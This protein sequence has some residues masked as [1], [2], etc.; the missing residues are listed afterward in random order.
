[1]SSEKDPFED[2][3]KLTD[4]TTSPIEV[5]RTLNRIGGVNVHRGV[6]EG[7]PVN[8]GA[9]FMVIGVGGFYGAGKDVY[10]DAVVDN[11]GFE[12]SFM[13][14]FLQKCIRI[15][16]PWIRIDKHVSHPLLRVVHWSPGDMVKY[17]D[18]ESW[19]NYEGA[20]EQKEVREWLQLMGTEVGRKILGED[21]WVRL[22][23]ED[24]LAIK[25]RG[26]NAIVTGIRYP[27][28]LALI[29]E[30]RGR[31]VWVTRPGFEPTGATATHSS[32]VTL[33][34]EDFDH[35]VLNDG[36]KKDLQYVATTQV[37]GWIDGWNGYE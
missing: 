36:A 16:N 32:E 10:A 15:I 23:R 4:P 12:K 31:L 2:A 33:T 29:H 7:F 25:E 30:F 35:E 37:N 11:V 8:T 1:M 26:H 20:K 13:S 17:A 27:N 9:P 21:T 5:Q 34:R 18:L 6:H 24:L 22:M 14:K 19:A 3:H 28:E